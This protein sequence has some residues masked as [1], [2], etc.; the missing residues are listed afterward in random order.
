M[1]ALITEPVAGAIEYSPAAVDFIIDHCGGN[2]FYIHNFCYQIF[3]RCVQEHRTYVNDN[4]VQIVRQQIL[5][6]LGPTNFAHFWEDNPEL[7]LTEKRK[8]TAEHCLA[9]CCIAVRGGAYESVD[10]LVE[11]QE[12]LP[13]SQ[14]EHATVRTI[15]SA[16]ERLKARKV[17]K[18]VPA[19]DATV[20]A[21][22]ILREWLAENAVTRL[23][24]VWTN[25]I[26]IARA[27]GIGLVQPQV[28]I[29]EQIAF[30]ISEDEMLAVSQRLLY[31][32]RQ[33]D[34]AE[35]RQWLKQFDDDNRIEVAFL[36]LKRLTEKGF[37][38]EGTRSRSLHKLQ[39]MVQNHRQEI[40]EKAWKVVRG[41]LDNLCISYVDSE[42]KSGAATARELSKIMRPGKC[43]AAGEIASWMRSHVDDDAI[44]AVVDDFAGT[45]DTLA[46]GLKTFERQIDP[47]I[48][49]SYLEKK[50]MVAYIMFAFPEAI[51]RVR[52]DFPKIEIMAAS[53]L[54]DELRALDDRAEIFPDEAECRFATEVLTQIGRELLPNSPLGYGD[55]GA[56]IVF[57]NAAPNNTLPV[58]W[59]N[60]RVNERPWKPLFPRA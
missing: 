60:G 10:E 39:E 29:G 3:D 8:Q 37:V 12:S 31:C 49:K 19:Q 22:P 15:R 52:H 13:L 27:E 38:N 23:L 58:F 53:S 25:Y 17:F 1:Q 11:V 26:G 54:G 5:Q 20:I 33:K 51:K 43:G 30:P 24:P 57:H 55:L 9:L 56:L 59:C 44:V 41:R 14:T 21:L 2:P 48:W 16:C 47:K 46:K 7:D 18:I 42:H 34:V 36:L 40:G 45:G 6:Q 28:Q 32:G 35:I 50:R 4:D